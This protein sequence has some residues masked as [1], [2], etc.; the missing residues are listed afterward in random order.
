MDRWL[1][2]LL[3]AASWTLSAILI[4][5]LWT[6]DSGLADRI[7]GT[8]LLLIPFAGPLLHWFVYNSLAPQAPHLQVRGA[9]GTYTHQWLAI[10]PVLD[11]MLEERRAQ[12]EQTKREDSP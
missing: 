5:K 2:F 9:R 4:L 11:R 1:F 7:G 12:D 10:R 6:R 3:F 8:V